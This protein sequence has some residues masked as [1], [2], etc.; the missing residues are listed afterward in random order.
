MSR[1]CRLDRPRDPV[2]A[3]AAAQVPHHP[4]ADLVVARP[5]VLGEKRGRRDELARRADPALEP[6]LADE[7]VLQRREFVAMREPLDGGHRATVDEDRGQKTGGEQ[8]TFDEHTAGSAHPDRAALF[9]P[10]G[11]EIIAKHVDEPS[12]RAHRER[13]RRTIQREAKTMHAQKNEYR[14]RRCASLPASPRFVIVTSRFTSA[15]SPYRNAAAGWS[16]RSRPGCSTRSPAR[17]S[18][19]AS[20]ARFAR[21]RSSP[22]V[23]WPAQ[24]PIGSID[25]ACCC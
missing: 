17:P 23:S 7:R 1:H 18:C 16:R 4:L 20:A 24:S 14:T 6:A 19:S 5:R 11:A 22:S 2:I 15:A 3:G 8:L 13:L 10:G 25:D 21:S 9:G 12:V